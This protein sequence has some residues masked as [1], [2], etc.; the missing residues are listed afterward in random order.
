MID[1]G[2]NEN[3]SVKIEVSNSKGISIANNGSTSNFNKNTDTTINSLGNKILNSL[4]EESNLTEQQLTD[5]K[6]YVEYYINEVGEKCNK[7][8]PR[9]S[10]QLFSN[11]KKFSERLKLTVQTSENLQKFLEIVQNCFN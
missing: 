6:Y 11:F 1:L 5:L 3:P 9:I 7:P 4:P 8:N 2:T 10:S